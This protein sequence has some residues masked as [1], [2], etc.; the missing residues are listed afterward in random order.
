MANT[1]LPKDPLSC[2][3]SWKLLIAPLGINYICLIVC[4][5][6]ISVIKTAVKEVK[7]VRYVIT[8][9]IRKNISVKGV[10]LSET[11]FLYKKVIVILL[12]VNYNKLCIKTFS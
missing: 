10:A 1:M 3:P 6:I 7:C 12:N 4:I 5:R 8:N 11:L 2:C 9:N